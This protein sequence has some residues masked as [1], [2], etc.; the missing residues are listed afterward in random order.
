MRALERADG[1]SAVVGVQMNR[2]RIV[3]VGSILAIAFLL[4]G[5][6]AAPAG[7]LP[8]P[9]TDA[10]SAQSQTTDSPAETTPLADSESGAETDAPTSTKSGSG[11]SGEACVAGNWK[12][13]NDLFAKIMLGLMKSDPDAATVAQGIKVSGDRLLWF[14]GDG[15]YGST[16][17]K[18]TMSMAG[19][20]EG[21]TM[22]AEFVIDSARL[23]NYGV[24]DGFLWVSETE[25]LFEESTLKVGDQISA[26]NSG[27]PTTEIN[28]FGFTGEI[29]NTIDR[30][31]MEGVAI[32]RCSGDVL[33]I[34]A[35]GG[36]ISRFTRT[37]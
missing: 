29:P 26:S 11:S 8:S 19:A 28:V 32:Y 3:G 14:S 12:M 16:D 21:T 15:Q 36:L 34:E 7:L 1:G 25:T 31:A 6:A 33:E 27:G 18:F 35:D 24:V 2:G 10:Q 37:Q 5:C 30:E 20:V 9:S 23:G 22:N 17:E 13:D 4:G